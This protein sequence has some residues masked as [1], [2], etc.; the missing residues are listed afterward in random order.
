MMGLALHRE[1]QLLILD[2]VAAGVDMEGEA[3]FYEILNE[4]R[5]KQN[6]TVILVSHDL[7]IVYQYATRVLCINHALICHGLPQ[8]VLTADTLGRLYG[9]GAVYHHPERPH[10]A[11]PN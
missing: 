10:P 8:E 7:S 6:L 3:V 5:A 4:L 1:P 11:V 2:E 9:H